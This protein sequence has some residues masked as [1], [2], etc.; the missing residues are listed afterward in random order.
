M[1]MSFCGDCEIQMRSIR[2]KA[3]HYLA[4]VGSRIRAK[5]FCS[6]SANVSIVSGNRN[7]FR[8]RMSWGRAAFALPPAPTIDFRRDR[9]RNKGGAVMPN[10]AAFQDVHR[11]AAYFEYSQ[12]ADPIGLGLIP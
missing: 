4:G 5:C 1:R 2:Q 8:G 12:A 11:D 3:S 9:G 7:G 6:V 10:D